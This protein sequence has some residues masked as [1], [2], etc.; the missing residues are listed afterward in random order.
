MFEALLVSWWVVLGV[1]WG[2]ISKKITGNAK[3]WAAEKSTR[4]TA[5]CGR[6]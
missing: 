3:G 5:N 1:S 6:R 2:E 4:A